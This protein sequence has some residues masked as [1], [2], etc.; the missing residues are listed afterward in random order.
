MVFDIQ[1]SVPESHDRIAD[2]F[3]DCAFM[4]DDRVGEWREQPVH[5]RGETLRVVLVDLGNGRETA[6]VAHQ[7][8][9][10][11]L[12]A[13]QHKFF[14]RLREL[15]DKRGSKI[16]PKSVADLTALCLHTL[17]CVESDDGGHHSQHKGRIGRIDKDAP[18]FK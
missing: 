11:A 6:Y 9:H 7:D 17:I 1:R 4:A 8:G 10:F 5:E 18:V 15:V 13:A 16:L 14:R 2:I 12:F 3:V